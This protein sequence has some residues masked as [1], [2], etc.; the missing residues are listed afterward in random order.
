MEMPREVAC[1]DMD[2]LHC[3]PLNLTLLCIHLIRQGDLKCGST[4]LIT[5]TL[6]FLSTLIGLY[7]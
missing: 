7:I 2:F 3:Y 4:D 1:S 5:A 6:C